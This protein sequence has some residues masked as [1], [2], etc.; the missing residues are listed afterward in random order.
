MA[1]G[2]EFPYN[3][4]KI[5][6]VMHRYFSHKVTTVKRG[7]SSYIWVVHSVLQYRLGYAI[8]EIRHMRASNSV[9]DLS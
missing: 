9:Y 3:C 4:I 8:A 6:H 5:K 1:K 2:K 7:G